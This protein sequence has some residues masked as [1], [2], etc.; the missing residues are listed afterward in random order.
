MSFAY[1]M[2]NVPDQAKV[3]AANLVVNMKE[4]IQKYPTAPVG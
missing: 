3:V 4:L 1:D 2:F